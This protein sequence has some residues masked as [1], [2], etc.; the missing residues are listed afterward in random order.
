FPER[1]LNGLAVVRPPR[2]PPR[3][4]RLT[5]VVRGAVAAMPDSLGA[6]GVA[7]MHFAL[8]GPAER[9]DGAG[10]DVVHGPPLMTAVVD[11]H[12]VIPGRRAGR[13]GDEQLLAEPAHA[14]PLEPRDVDGLTLVVHVRVPRPQRGD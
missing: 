11:E 13:D 7:V 3:H 12:P 14:S 10:G 1:L 6:G 2:P 9:R 8:P 5:A 4:D